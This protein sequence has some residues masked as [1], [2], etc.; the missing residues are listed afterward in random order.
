MPEDIILK[1]E[2]GESKLE[3]QAIVSQTCLVF[4]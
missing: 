3:P 2:V 4:K 1:L